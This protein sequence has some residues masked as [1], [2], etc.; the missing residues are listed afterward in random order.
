[1]RNS[2]LRGYGA[3]LL[4]Y[5]YDLGIGPRGF[6]KPD[7]HED[8]PWFFPYDDVHGRIVRIDPTFFSRSEEVEASF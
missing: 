6:L 5:V 1:M 3:G 8:P 2:H 7:H 4:Q